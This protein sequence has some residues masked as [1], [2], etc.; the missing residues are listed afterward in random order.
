LA[1][2]YDVTIITV[3]PNAHPQALAVLEK[4]LAGDNKLL[5]CWYC[6]IGALNQIMIIRDGTD[7]AASL[8][9]RQAALSDKNPFGIRELI[10]AMT[11]DTYV[12][13]DVMAPLKPG[14]F[15]PC[16]EVRTYTLKYDGLAATAALWR[17]WVPKRQTVSPVLAAM[18]AVT[19]PA[20][21]FMHIWPY[22]SLDE[23]VRLR[24]KAVTDGVWPPPGGP[25][26][27]ASQQSDIYLP[28]PFSPMK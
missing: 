28:A 3:S 23:R 24:T 6:D 21:R 1:A 15:G 11:M 9:W 12:P 4:T 19:G 27:L 7:A 2:H 10:A 18:S 8:A 14:S 16:Y 5:A 13:F 20:I 26:L 22:P 25:T 17:E